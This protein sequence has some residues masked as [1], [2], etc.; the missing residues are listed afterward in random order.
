VQRSRD[1]VGAGC[2]SSVS[3]HERGCGRQSVA[4]HRHSTRQDD[5]ASRTPACPLTSPSTSFSTTYCAPLC[6]HTHTGLVSARPGVHRRVYSDPNRLCMAGPNHLL[7]SFAEAKLLH[8][9]S[10]LLLVERSN[11]TRRAHRWDCWYLRVIFLANAPT[12]FLLA[13]NLYRL[14]RA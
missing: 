7:L 10:L 1:L 11:S 9:A 8:L 2:C 4:R 6:I 13:H 14:A 5:E 12:A 3:D